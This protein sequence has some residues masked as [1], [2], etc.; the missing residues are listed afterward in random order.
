[1]PPILPVP[2]NYYAILGISPSADI[3]AI[4]ISFRR[5]AWR[6]HP[7]RNVAPDAT[8]QFKSIS[9][10][11]YVLSDRAR[12][13]RHGA[14]WSAQ[15]GSFN[16]TTSVQPRPRLRHRRRGR[17][18]CGCGDASAS[19]LLIPTFWVALLIAL[20]PVLNSLSLL[21]SPSEL[22][23]MPSGCSLSSILL[24]INSNICE[25]VVM[26]GYSGGH[27]WT[28]WSPIFDLREQCKLLPAN[29]IDFP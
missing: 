13:A 2:V 12:R 9:E 16:W 28:D 18:P 17:R 25:G 7:D 11:H 24:T 6:Y 3:T 14:I 8:V 10:A 27:R 23:G 21:D 1:M 20:R 15:F 26:T 22:S 29:A 19:A 5:L 4:N